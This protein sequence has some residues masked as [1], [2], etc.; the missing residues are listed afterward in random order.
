MSV[1]QVKA[2]FE[3]VEEDKALQEKL[4]A[5]DKKAKKA[6]DTAIDEL[7]EIARMEGFIFTPQDLVDARNQKPETSEQLQPWARAN[8][9]QFTGVGCMPGMG[10]YVSVPVPPPNSPDPPQEPGCVST[11][12]L[13]CVGHIFR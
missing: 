9:E 4:K 11:Y 6:L 12:M 7:V 3:K 2:F 8:C 13:E 1:I 10:L 5:L